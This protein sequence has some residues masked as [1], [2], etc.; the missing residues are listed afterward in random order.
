MS[1]VLSVK[2]LPLTLEHMY[3]IIEGK[4]TEL[5]NGGDT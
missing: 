5:R 3:G 1:N 4:I 2:I